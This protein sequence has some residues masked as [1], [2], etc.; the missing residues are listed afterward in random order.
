MAS[1]YSTNLRLEL[2]ATGENRSTW[3]TKANND[4]SLIEAAITGYESIAMA[5]ANVT[6]TSVNGGAD[7][8]RKMYLNF[9]GAHT[10]I[11]TVTIP[12]V[13]KVYIMAN[14]TTGGFGLTVSNGVNTASI[15]TGETC[16]IW[17]NGSTVSKFAL[18]ASGGSFT[19]LAASST[20]TVGGATTLAALAATT[21]TFSGAISSPSGALT[22]LT[23]AGR[24]FTQQVF[25]ASTTWTKTSGAIRAIFEGVGGG[26]GGG[27]CDGQ[28]ATTSQA[29]GGG[30][31]GFY[32]MTP[33]LDISGVA[34]AVVTI[35][36]AGAAGAAGANNGGNGGST[37][38]TIGATT[39]T[40]GGGTG[41][42][43]NIAGTT[44]GGS[45]IGG[46]GGS[47]TNVEGGSWAGGSSTYTTDNYGAGTSSNVTSGS[48]GSN[49]FGRG[50]VGA[51]FFSPTVSSVPVAGAGRGAGGSGVGVAQTTGNVAGGAGSAGYMR[52]WEFY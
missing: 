1:T 11:R 27:G 41:S 52:I 17:T 48:G 26:G 23:L 31:S 8:A 12:T 46:A 28:G 49:P 36:A 3:G 40:W 43:G 24:P 32:G 42:T 20:L 4:F 47:G 35:G 44:V 22:A 29:T 33:I 45:D 13:S 16:L 5:N 37:T 21:G 39:Y 15:G 6:L 9:T 18:V 2:M 14:A 50:G 51:H 25:S 38:I 30:G 7:Q 34:S 19:T 10:A